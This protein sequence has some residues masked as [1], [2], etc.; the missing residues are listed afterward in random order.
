VLA[1][2]VAGLAWGYPRLAW[3]AVNDLRDRKLVTE[4]P[5]VTLDRPQTSVS[6]SQERYLLRRLR[7][8]PTPTTPRVHV[9]VRWNAGVCARVR[10]GQYTG[11]LGAEWKD[12]LFVCV[13]GEWVP[14]YTFSDLMA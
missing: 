9:E 12:T 14:A 11:P 6:R 8:S 13:F 7:E 10:A 4:A 2:Y 3:V 1:L 5:A